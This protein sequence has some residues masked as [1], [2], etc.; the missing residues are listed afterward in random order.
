[1]VSRPSTILAI[2]AVWLLKWLDVTLGDY[3]PWQ[4]LARRLDALRAWIELVGLTWLEEAIVYCLER[5]GQRRV[6]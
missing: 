6:S 2:A 3:L 4:V 5:E 1:M